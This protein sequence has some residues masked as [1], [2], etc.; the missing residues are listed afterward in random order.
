M[1]MKKLKN[2]LI[3]IVEQKKEILKV[4]DDY[5]KCSFEELMAKYN[6]K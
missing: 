5:L 1:H 6:R 2:I 3:E 4:L